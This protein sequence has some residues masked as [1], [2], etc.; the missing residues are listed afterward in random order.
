[1]FVEITTDG[2]TKILVN[3]DRVD[4]I[5]ATNSFVMIGGERLQIHKDS[6]AIEKIRDALLAK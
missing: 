6:D 5:N 2:K 4:Y 3:S 1:M